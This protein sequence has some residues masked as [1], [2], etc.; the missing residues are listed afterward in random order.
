MKSERVTLYSITRNQV[1]RKRGDNDEGVS[2]H[3]N[4]DPNSRLF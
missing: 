3:R 4:V 1:K 2:G